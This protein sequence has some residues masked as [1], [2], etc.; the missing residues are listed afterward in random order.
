LNLGRIVI[1]RVWNGFVVKITR[2]NFPT[3][4][5]CKTPSEVIDLL[6]TELTRGGRG[7]EH[8]G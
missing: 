6:K 5:V 4:Y 7:E 2:H 8:G 1:E 3:V